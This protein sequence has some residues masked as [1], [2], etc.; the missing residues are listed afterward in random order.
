MTSQF[1]ATFGN[2]KGMQM[3]T[4]NYND[5]FDRDSVDFGFNNDLHNDLSYGRQQNN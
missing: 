2:S 4:T 1:G 3:R 5:S